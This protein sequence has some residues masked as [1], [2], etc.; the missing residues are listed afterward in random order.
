M[1]EPA[2][3]GESINQVAARWIRLYVATARSAKN[4]GMAA[5]RVRDYLAP[6]MGDL[7]LGAV[8]PDDVRQY[9]L[10]LHG[11]GLALRTV[12]HL[13]TD[14]RSMLNW[15]AETGLLPRSPFPRRVMPRIQETPPNRLADWEVSA[16]LAVPEPHAFVIRLALET[17]LRWGELCAARQ[18]HVQSGMLVVARTKSTRIRRVPL[19]NWL[20]REISRGPARLVPFS[21]AAS[22]SFAKVVRRRSGVARFHVHQCRHT[23]AC[24]WIERGGSL[25]ALQQILGHASVVTTQMY[26]RL[27]DDSVRREA[28]RINGAA[29]SW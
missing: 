27:S 2:G 6:F 23:F 22:S 25:P 10:Y 7:P 1:L 29:D 11:R 17:G 18:E 20:Q 16:V 3:S 19:P 4:V 12:R 21:P 28:A 26:A 15:A 13:L 14:L 8:G 24:R 5:Q 9:R